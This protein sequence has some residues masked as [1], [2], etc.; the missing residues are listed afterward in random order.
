MRASI[1]A[2][3]GIHAYPMIMTGLTLHDHATNSE[4]AAMS[5]PNDPTNDSVR[6]PGSVDDISSAGTGFDKPADD[7]IIAAILTAGMLPTLPVPKLHRVAHGW[8]D[9]DLRPM[10]ELVA[11]A[12]TLYRAMLETMRQANGRAPDED[13][14]N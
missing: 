6:E 7:E 12:L 9:A 14:P 3:I 1:I 11:S 8:H 10:A 5:E 4:S 13:E 2:D